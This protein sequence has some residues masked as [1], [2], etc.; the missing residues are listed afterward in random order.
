MPQGPVK[1]LRQTRQGADVGAEVTEVEVPTHLGRTS[2][3]AQKRLCPLDATHQESTEIMFLSARPVATRRL[4]TLG[5]DT[6]QNRLT[7]S[8]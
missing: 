1:T 6:G 2:E 5:F 7:S 8:P 3:R 4:E